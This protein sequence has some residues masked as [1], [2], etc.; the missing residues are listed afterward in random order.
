MV[1]TAPASAR[2]VYSA[3]AP[4]PQGWAPEAPGFVRRLWLF[5]SSDFRRRLAKVRAARDM[6]GLQPCVA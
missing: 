6:F 3:E 4:T 5:G 2:G 1:T